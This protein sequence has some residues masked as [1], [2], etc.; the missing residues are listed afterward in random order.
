MEQGAWFIHTWMAVNSLSVN[1]SVVGRCGGGEGGLQEWG[2]GFVI[3]LEG[4]RQ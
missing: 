4:D 2:L 1:L 3:S